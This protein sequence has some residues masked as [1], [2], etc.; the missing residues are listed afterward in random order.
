MLSKLIHFGFIFILLVMNENYSQNIHTNNQF[1]DFEQERWKDYINNSNSIIA[2]PNIDIL[3]YHLNL[4]IKIS[5]PF[6]KGY[7]KS[8]FQVQNDNVN[9]ILLNLHN[10]LNIDSITGISNSFK[11][12]NNLITIEPFQLLNSG[13]TVELF[14]YYSGIPQLWENK[15]GLR[16]ELHGQNEPIIASLS[17]PFLSY[18]WWP[19]KDGPTDKADSVYIDITIPDSVINNLPLMAVSNGTLEG[20]TT[21]N[22]K[23]TFHWRE[24]YPIVPYYVMVAISNYREIKQSFRFPLSYYTFQ[25]NFNQTQN[26]VKDIPEVIDLFS[27]LF[28]PY[29]FEKE[30]Y[31]MTELGYYGAIENQTNTIIN[32]MSNDWF[33]ISVHELAHMWFGDMITCK[34]WQHAWLNEGFATYSE[35]L[36]IEHKYGFSAYQEYM[37]HLEYKDKGSIYLNDDS[38]PS[39]IFLS[40]I[41]HKGAYFLHMLRGILGDSIFFEAIY[42]YANSNNF[43]YKHAITEDFQNICEVVSGKKLNYLFEQWIYGENYPI[44]SADWSYINSSHDIYTVTLKLNQQIHSNPPFFEMPI[45]IQ[46]TTSTADTIFT[47]YN[48]QQSQTFQFEVNGL[49]KELKIDP[50][51][52]LLKDSI[53]ADLTIIIPDKTQLSQNFPNPFNPSTIIKYSIKHYLHVNL[54][55]FDVLGRKLTTLVNYEQSPGEYQIS[56]NVNDLNKEISSGIYYYRLIVGNYSQTKKMVLLK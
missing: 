15:K 52:W 40:I 56:L 48:N 12:E 1:H 8:I 13:D 33:L 45:E 25:E 10:S 22:N 11:F 51:N 35:A 24:R 3:F 5:S 16:Y 6:I 21:N 32:N 26:G 20:I 53:N 27:K 19:C 31:A 46:I 34:N 7:V 2:D 14:I 28:G 38:D 4:E 36:W 23:K 18:Y 44:Y 47:V 30:K 55:L 29:P 39:K 50:N 49:P 41:Y 54:S 42:K 9:K 17:T 37:N 43:K